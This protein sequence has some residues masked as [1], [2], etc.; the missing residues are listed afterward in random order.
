MHGSPE[1]LQK[2][3]HESVAALLLAW[4][5]SLLFYGSSALGVGVGGGWEILVP[6]VGLFVQPSTRYYLLTTFIPSVL[7]TWKK[8][9]WSEIWRRAWLILVAPFPKLLFV[10]DISPKR[11][12][13]LYWKE[14]ARHLPK[15]VR[16][17][18]QSVCEIVDKWTQSLMKK[19]IQKSVETS[20][21]VVYDNV[22]DFTFMMD[23]NM[24]GD[25]DSNDEVVVAVEETDLC[26]LK[27][28]DEDSRAVVDIFVNSAKDDSE[29]VVGQAIDGYD[30]QEDMPKLV[31]EDDFETANGAG[32]S[33]EKR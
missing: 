6:V 1:M 30:N 17:G 20:I 32:N 29:I 28:E 26:D 25:D 10:P 31:D 7:Q 19:T 8:M 15:S 27:E 4:I 23:V 22:A 9:L 12:G 2:T 33:D 3:L 18:L 21:G 5:P 14:R 11:Q 13:S 24:L 16:K